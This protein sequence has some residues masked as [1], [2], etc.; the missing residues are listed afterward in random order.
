[1]HCLEQIVRI[2]C[3]EKREPH[4]LRL[5]PRIYA[6]RQSIRGMAVSSAYVA[7]LYNSL[8][9]YADQIIARPHY[10]PEEGWGDLEALQQVTLADMLEEVITADIAQRSEGS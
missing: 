9:R 10:R 2:N 5:H 6:L 7:Q 8:Y 4:P 1:M 3:A